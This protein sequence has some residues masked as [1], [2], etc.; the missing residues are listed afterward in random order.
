M[1]SRRGI[2]KHEYEYPAMNEQEWYDGDYNH[3]CEMSGIW[4]HYE[5]T[6][7]DISIFI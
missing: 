2:T 4:H 3:N 6:I 7:A 5:S 1:G